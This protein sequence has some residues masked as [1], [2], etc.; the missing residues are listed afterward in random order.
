MGSCFSKSDKEPATTKRTTGNDRF[1]RSE[2]KLGS[3]TESGTA[4][5]GN[6][7]ID[8]KYTGSTNRNV[9][10]S[11]NRNQGKPLGGEINEKNPNTREAVAKA[12]ELRYNKQ[13]QLLKE[14]QDKLKTM[15]RKSKQEKGLQS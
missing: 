13:R 7:I 8:E 2:Q 1:T 12:A 10:E 15:S 5:N 14:S 4:G 3:N 9:Q 11:T 6:N